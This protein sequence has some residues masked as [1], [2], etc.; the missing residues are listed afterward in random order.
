MTSNRGASNI[1]CVAF[2]CGGVLAKDVPGIMF[3]KLALRYPESDQ[4]RIRRCHE[5]NYEC[6]NKFKLDPS[7]TEDMYW[8]DVINQEKLNES[9]DEL[10][11]LLRSTF[12]HYPITFDVVKKLK[13]KGYELGICSNH[14][15]EWFQS[16][17]DKIKIY[18]LFQKPL[19]IISQEVGVAKPST[20]IFHLLHRRFSNKL[21]RELETSEILF[22]DDKEANVQAAENAGLRAFQFDGERH[23]AAYLAN[24]FAKFNISL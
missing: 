6:W 23:D 18:D 1:R 5:R 10:K 20:E 12:Q 15:I 3:E 7:Y 13:T 8:R 2:D 9:I 19:V 14:S 21:G 17:A 11:Q 22:L 24:N 4:D 16:I